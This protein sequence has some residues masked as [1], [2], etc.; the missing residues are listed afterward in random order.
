MGYLSARDMAQQAPN[1]DVALEWH[2][3]S[4]H[5][6]PLPYEL[7]PVAKRIIEVVH[8]DGAAAGDTVDLLEG[9][10]W[11]GKSYAPLY[12]CIEAWHL[13]AFLETDNEE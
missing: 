8:N 5:F 4:N 3:R 2:F 12:A 11:R 7:I 6:P 13:D 1:L 9:T 10:T